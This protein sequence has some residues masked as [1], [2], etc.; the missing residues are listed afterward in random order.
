MFVGKT[1][2]ADG[3]WVGVELSLPEGKND[4]SVKGTRYFRC[5]PGH[6]LFV[7]LKAVSKVTPG[8][9]V[10][11]C[12]GSGGRAEKASG[13]GSAHVAAAGVA[14]MRI[15][16]GRSSLFDEIVIG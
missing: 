15:S 3:D 2:F 1:G 7:R 5:R 14:S 8:R 12:R 6:G 11:T 10:P 4:G 16:K 9:P 13:D